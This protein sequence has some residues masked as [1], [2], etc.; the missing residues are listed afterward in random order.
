[1]RPACRRETARLARCDRRVV[2]PNRADGWGR[3]SGAA[4]PQS[5][6]HDAET[7]GPAQC[8]VVRATSEL[9]PRYPLRVASPRW[10]AFLLRLDKIAPR[11]DCASTRLRR[12]MVADAPQVRTQKNHAVRVARRCN[13]GD[14]MPRWRVTFWIGHRDAPAPV[15][16][17][18]RRRRSPGP[19]DSAAELIMGPVTAKLCNLA[20]RATQ[21]DLP[22]QASLWIV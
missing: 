10:R 20:S 5:E 3:V 22:W 1:V 9:D 18:E 4:F 8:R 17:P 19:P 15:S 16:T 7:S 12:A 6:S 11:Q 21:P 2:G 13:Y 14:C